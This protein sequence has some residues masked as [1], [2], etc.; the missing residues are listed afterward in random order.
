MTSNLRQPSPCFFTEL[1][2]DVLQVGAR[3]V[4]SGM[5]LP[6]VEGGCHVPTHP[7]RGRWGAVVLSGSRCW[8]APTGAA[9]DLLQFEDTVP[10]RFPMTRGLEYEP[11]ASVSGTHQR[12]GP[13]RVCIDHGVCHT[14]ASRRDHS[15]THVGRI[16]HCKFMV[17]PPVAPWRRN[18]PL[19]L[20]R[21]LISGQV[22][23]GRFGSNT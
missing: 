2:I 13:G 1:R 8:L 20:L 7:Q 22:C 16:R 21:S 10:V 3:E 19:F 4:S 14:V 11:L 15:I 6:V 23:F 18:S 5:S 12:Y 9:G 17:S